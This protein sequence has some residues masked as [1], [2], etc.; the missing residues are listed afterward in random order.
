M[1]Y[2]TLG[3]QGT[4]FSRCLKMVEELVEKRNL[5]GEIIAQVGASLYRPKGVKCFDFVQETDY[6][7]YIQNADVIITHAGSGALFSCIKKGKKT[8]A[9][10]RLSK[11][12][13]MVDD[14]QIE[15]VHKLTEGG[16]ILDGTYSIIDAWDKLEGFIP[17]PNDFECVLPQRIDEILKGWGITCKKYL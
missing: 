17:R 2:I 13:E 4:D 7:K 15:L 6:Q 14:H 11:Y 16:Y 8:I 3:T 10:A 5:K 9:V 1:I 12:N